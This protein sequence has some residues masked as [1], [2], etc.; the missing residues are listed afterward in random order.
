MDQGL[1]N[2]LPSDPFE[3]PKVVDSLIKGDIFMHILGDWKKL[4][5]L[6]AR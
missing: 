3:L 1:L 4:K 2:F 6:S 5:N